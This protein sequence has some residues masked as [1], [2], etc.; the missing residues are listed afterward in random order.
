VKGQKVNL[1]SKETWLREKER[2]CVE[3]TETRE[4]KGAEPGEVSAEAGDCENEKSR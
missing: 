1:E 2:S 4:Q 3:K